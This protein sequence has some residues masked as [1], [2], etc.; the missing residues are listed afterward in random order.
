MTAAHRGSVSRGR[1]GSRRGQGEAAE[2]DRRGAW[3]EEEKKTGHGLIYTKGLRHRVIISTGAFEGLRHRF[4][5]HPVPYVT[6]SHR[7]IIPP[8]TLGLQRAG[9]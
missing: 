8:G 1:R 3:K 6:Q 9:V 7:V 2:D 5:T 4:V